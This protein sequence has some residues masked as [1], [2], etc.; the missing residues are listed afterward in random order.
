[1]RA[2][3]LAKATVAAFVPLRAC[4]PMAQRVSGSVLSAPWRSTV[5][6]PVNQRHAHIGIA[7]FVDAEQ[8]LFA[9]AGMFA[10]R[11]ARIRGHVTPFWKAYRVTHGRH[12]G[13]GRDGTHA[14]EGIDTLRQGIRPACLC[15]A[16][17]ILCDAFI[18]FLPLCL[19]PG[20]VGAHFV[21]T[22]KH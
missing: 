12:Q 10:R 17:I 19:Q 20:R 2:S 8:G 16:F 6:R 14:W 22:R 21:P 5:R 11:Q 7:A 15:D 4:K 3:L 1:M 18:Q 9:V 13:G